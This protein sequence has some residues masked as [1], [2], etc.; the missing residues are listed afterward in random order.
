MPRR[1]VFAGISLSRL[2]IGIVLLIGMIV[3]GG[4][5]AGVL[6]IPSV[7]AMD[8]TFGEVTD[9]NTTIETQLVVSNPNPIALTVG[10]V[11]VA[12]TIAMNDVEV[13]HGERAGL[14]IGQ[15]NAT[16]P[17]A[18]QLQ[19][20]AIGPWWESHI[21]NNEQSEVRVDASVMTDRFNRSADI[22]HTHSVETDIIA[23]FNSDE[24]RPIDAN[25][26]LVDD[27]V[28][29]VNQT[30]GSWGPVADQQT[31]IEKEFVL[32]NPNLEP[33]V[34]TRM[35]YEITLNGVPVGTGETTRELV[36][37]GHSSEELELVTAIDT[38][39]L[40]AWWVTHLDDDVYGHQVSLFTIE[41]WAIIEL[42][43]GEQL[44]LGLDELTYHE[45]IGTDMFDEGGDV[46][47]PP[48]EPADDDGATI[49][50]GND[51]TDDG[52]ADDG[53]DADTDDRDDGDDG[54]EAADDGLLDDSDVL[55]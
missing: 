23:S 14:T 48:E 10:S 47:V 28:L 44:E 20:A 35:G 18:T 55:G 52:V 21:A 3:V 26:V 11:T 40:D 53:E 51:E 43:G 29:Y 38:T 25:S 33:Y 16:I 1:A 31:P 12:Y 13:A 54:E 24:A 49:D 37:A 41:F 36:I 6:G 8:H 50:D 19:H 9:D 15:G 39:T 7:A 27:P 22:S 46:G 5:L 45:F 17:L 4:V 42:P 34:L 30:R 32:F 2:L